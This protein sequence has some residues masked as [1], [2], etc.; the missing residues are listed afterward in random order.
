MK[1]YFKKN[2][3]FV[4]LVTLSTTIFIPMALL[5]GLAVAVALYAGI[6]LGMGAMRMTDGLRELSGGQVDLSET[7]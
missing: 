7:D 1:A 5:L 3:G 4:T 6:A 2:S